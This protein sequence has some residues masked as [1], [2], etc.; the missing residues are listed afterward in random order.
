MIS[1]A[2]RKAGSAWI[3]KVGAGF[4]SKQAE[5]LYQVSGCP[6]RLTVFPRREP[7]TWVSYV[8]LHWSVVNELIEGVG[9]ILIN[10]QSFGLASASCLPCLW[11][12]EQQVSM[13]FCHLSH[14]QNLTTIWEEGIWAK[15]EFCCTALSTVLRRQAQAKC[16]SHKVCLPACESTKVQFWR[17]HS[18]CQTKVPTDIFSASGTRFPKRAKVMSFTLKDK[19]D[20][21]LCDDA[22][23]WYGIS[24]YLLR[25]KAHPRDQ[26]K[27]QHFLHSV[28][29]ISLRWRRKSQ[30][31]TRK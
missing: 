21:L 2:K 18:F 10:A 16:I 9:S 23:R 28:Q 31:N 19:T 11:Q 22:C 15:A 1:N 5:S 27:S 6:K 25:T 29:L 12:H 24:V 30:E 4:E 8:P 13:K 26:I 7:E 14:E 3:E 20:E 17:Q